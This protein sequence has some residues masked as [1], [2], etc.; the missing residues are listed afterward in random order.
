MIEYKLVRGPCQTHKPWDSS[1][2]TIETV[3]EKE[4]TP[5][6]PIAVH[7][8]PRETRTGVEEAIASQE[9]EYKMPSPLF[10]CVQRFL[11]PSTPTPDARVNK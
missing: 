11:T 7:K 10:P 4:R 6:V 1:S 8:H 9:R 3:N 5:I 2:P